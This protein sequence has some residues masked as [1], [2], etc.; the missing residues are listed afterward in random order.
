ML[1]AACLAQ[2]VLAGCGGGSTSLSPQQ[3]LCDSV[4]ELRTSANE[5][6]GLSLDST[7]AEVQQSVDGFLI[8]LE[9]VSDSV[10]GVLQSNVDTVEKSL[11]QLSAQL[12]S[13]PDSASIGDVVA[14]VQQSIP[15]LRA[16]IDEVLAGVDCSGT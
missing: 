12:G 3:Q 1:L 8:A 4:S 6:R 7:R 9:N 15:A 5:L 13:L 14:A 11:D 10:G 16:A 2:A